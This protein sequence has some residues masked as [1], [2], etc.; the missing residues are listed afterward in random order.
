MGFSGPRGSP[1]CSLE[2]GCGGRCRG[3]SGS[4]SSRRA[5]GCRCK[6]VR[7][8]F[9]LST[10]SQGARSDAEVDGPR[11]VRRSAES[12]VRASCVVSSGSSS[13]RWRHRFRSYGA[14]SSAASTRGS[15]SVEG[16]EVP[17]PVFEPLSLLRACSRRGGDTARVR[18]A[19]GRRSDPQRQFRREGTGLGPRQPPPRA[20]ACSGPDDP[21]NWHRGSVCA[22]KRGFGSGLA[23]GDVGRATGA[24]IRNGLARSLARSIA[25]AR[26]RAGARSTVRRVTAVA[27]VAARSC[28][29]AGHP[30]GVELCGSCGVV[31]GDTGDSRWFV[32]PGRVDSVATSGLRS[33]GTRIGGLARLVLRCAAGTRWSV[34]CAAAA[35]NA[36]GGCRGAFGLRGGNLLR[37]GRPRVERPALTGAS[38]AGRRFGGG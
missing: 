12:N 8:S 38:S 1:P 15:R 19:V 17:E 25:F 35:P 23:G 33:P 11:S 16:A 27:S 5:C 22:M 10:R 3:P 20:G 2:C 6:D 4:W 30:F 34:R 36:G 7:S 24:S 9:G 29:V 26:C 14:S 37:R 21:I 18:R 13:K 32:E 31:R 28:R